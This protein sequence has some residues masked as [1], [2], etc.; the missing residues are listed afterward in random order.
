[1]FTGAQALAT[2]PSS[3]RDATEATVRRNYWSLLDMGLSESD[4]QQL[5]HKAPHVFEELPQDTSALRAKLQWCREMMG[6]SVRDV[7]LHHRGF[8]TEGLRG[9][10]QRVSQWLTIE[11]S[12]VWPW[13]YTSSPC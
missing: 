8:L 6:L 9:L 13:G 1:M 2:D 5:W 7:L 4:A 3:S 11:Y 12:L 10:E